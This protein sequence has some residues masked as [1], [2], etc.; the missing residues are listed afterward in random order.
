MIT[1]NQKKLLIAF[2]YDDAVND[3]GWKHED[4]SCWNSC[5]AYDMVQNG[6]RPQSVGGVIAKASEAGLIRTCG[7]EDGNTSLTD[8]GRAELGKLIEEEEASQSALK[9]QDA[10][11]QELG[12]QLLPF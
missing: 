9:N 5:L 2:S 6:I 8:L 3:Y 10:I 1:E 11:R 4:A 7:G 12:K